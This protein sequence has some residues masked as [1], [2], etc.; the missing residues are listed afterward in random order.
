MNPVVYLLPHCD[1]E[2]FSLPLIDYFKNNLQVFITLTNGLDK[3]GKGINVNRH[4]EFA[5]SMKVLSKIGVQAEFFAF[6]EEHFLRDGHLHSDLTLEKL[7][8]L[9]K[10]LREINPSLIVAP[11]L[12]GGHQD[13]DSA[14]VIGQNIARRIGSE[15]IF[16]S[17]YRSAHKYLPL[18]SVMAP[19]VI[20]QR[21]R[22][23]RLFISQVAMKMIFTYKSQFRTFS[24]LGMPIL[25]KYIFG[26]WHT[27]SEIDL[28]HPF[29]SLYQ[30]RGRANSEVVNQ[31]LQRIE[32]E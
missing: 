13:H 4:N 26:Q 16:F 24:G 14:A 3:E 11:A 7:A 32:N 30:L 12:E 22:Y 9:T 15:V 31:H 25:C 1:D 19:I 10:K 21:F 18:F 23:Q 5:K 28:E 17:T 6:G 8:L 27:A 20:G 2:I 29:V